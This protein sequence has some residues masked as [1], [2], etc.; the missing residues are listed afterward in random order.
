[1][2]QAGPPLEVVVVDN[3][4][5]DGTAAVLRSFKGRIRVIQ[6]ADNIG[7]AAGQN[8]AIRACRGT[9][10]VLT[11]NPDVLLGPGFVQGLVESGASDSSVG[12]VCGKLL[13]IA[14]GFK[15]LPE[16]RIDSA[17]MYFTP[18]HAPFRPRLA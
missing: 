5:T 15:H 16:P 13:S 2:A 17:G 7:F 18:E 12:A 3:A 9:H 1:L 8:M 10:W 11:L 6:N 4:S 14:P